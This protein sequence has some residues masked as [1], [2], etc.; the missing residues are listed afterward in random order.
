MNRLKKLLNNKNKIFN[1]IIMALF[2]LNILT[3]TISA[4]GITPDSVSSS[5]GEI[6][7]LI[8]TVL[9]VVGICFI[10]SGAISIAEGIKE[11]N[12]NAKSRGYKEIAGGAGIIMVSWVGVPI[13]TK[14]I[15]EGIT[16]AAS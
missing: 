15:K 2:V 4:A 6:M 3:T 13:L 16:G 12:P 5:V 14:F 10:F 8:K 9:T 1:Y 11:E 7:D